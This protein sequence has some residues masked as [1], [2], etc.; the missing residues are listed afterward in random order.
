MN[1]SQ[2]A[3]SL[4][5]GFGLIPLGSPTTIFLSITS[6][7]FAACQHQKNILEHKARENGIPAKRVFIPECDETGEYVRIQ[8]FGKYRWC[9]D[10]AGHEIQGTRVPAPLTPNCQSKP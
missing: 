9:V 5:Y 10:S 1:Q 3:S 6:N 2:V 4:C 8:T 7:G